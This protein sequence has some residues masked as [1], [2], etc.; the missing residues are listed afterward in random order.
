[1]TI[2]LTICFCFLP[3]FIGLTVFG[4]RNEWDFA[5]L[6]QVLHEMNLAI[7][8]WV[9]PDRGIVHPVYDP[10]WCRPARISAAWKALGQ[11][12]R[13]YPVEVARQAAKRYT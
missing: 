3:V 7:A 10:T 8:R 13:R 2:F 1:M 9:L 11:M 12:R 4:M 6:A 5:F